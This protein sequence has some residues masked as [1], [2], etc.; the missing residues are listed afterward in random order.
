MSPQAG[1][2]ARAYTSGCV[3]SHCCTAT[4]ALQGREPG[5]FLVRYA[6]VPAMYTICFVDEQ[7]RLCHTRVRREPAP[8]H[9]GTSAR[10]S[11]SARADVST[12]TGVA[13]IAAAAVAAARRDSRVI[14]TADGD[15][16]A[17]DDDSAVNSA[18]RF[19]AA[20]DADSSSS[21]DDDDDSAA[22]SR[23]TRAKGG[24]VASLAQLIAV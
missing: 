12:A 11:D 24:D 9:S 13:A 22:E 3:C 1:V 2:C 18:C 15:D 5:T 23:A 14:N 20:N 7:R 17:S 6:L 19:V 21:D 8:A 10:S 4:Q 16:D